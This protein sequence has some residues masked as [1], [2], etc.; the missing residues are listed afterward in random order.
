MT[1]PETPS[2]DSA[3]EIP[4][5]ASAAS[6]LLVERAR[7][8]EGRE[9][10]EAY[11]RALVE[12]NQLVNLVSRQDT[13][14]HVERFTLE[15]AFLGNLL[16]AD[17]KRV[18]T[19]SPRLLDLGSGGGFPGLVLKT[20][21]PDLDTTLV[22]ATQKK[23]RFLAEICRQL[24]LR[25]VTVIAAR[26]EALSQRGSPFFRP[27]FRHYFDWVTAKALG[28]VAESTR[29]AAPF[30]RVD[31]IHWTFKGA[32]VKKETQAANRVLKQLR[33]K[34]FRVDR[35]PGEQES[36]VAS[37]R[38]LAQVEPGPRRSRPA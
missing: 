10:L 12:H 36:Y 4:R 15:C 18:G 8:A 3:S 5:I 38:R 27:E 20:L 19:E 32:G 16:I 25:S 24:D 17:S 29:L 9:R 14:R 28:S 26:A 1:D 35:I 37:F 31:G 33:F 2:A 11:L 30:L 7:T 6:E 21:L 13:L 34:P 22:E 23:A